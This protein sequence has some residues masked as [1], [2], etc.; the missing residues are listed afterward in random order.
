[1]GFISAGNQEVIE[2]KIG[3]VGRNGI[4]LFDKLGAKTRV[5]QTAQN[6]GVK[7]VQIRNGNP[8][9]DIYRHLIPL[10][11]FDLTEPP[12]ESAELEKLVNELPDEIFT[13]IQ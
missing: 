3:R 5:Y 9:L 8:L 6:S 1:M 12:S 11:K 13:I 2:D 4:I 7:L 10:A